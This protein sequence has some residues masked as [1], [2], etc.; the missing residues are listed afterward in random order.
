MAMAV[1]AAMPEITAV[2]ICRLAK[3]PAP[4]AFQRGSKPKMKAKDVMSTGRNRS[5]A[6]SS[7]P[8]TSG[9]PFSNYPLANSTI[10]I[11]FFAD[12]PMS[13]TS[14]IWP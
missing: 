3:P 10:K 8:S 7:A 5:F 14:P 11:A 12:R 13:I 9:R 4:D 6:P 2:P 1:A